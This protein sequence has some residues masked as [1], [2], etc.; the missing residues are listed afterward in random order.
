[1]INPNVSLK[2]EDVHLV[3]QL[4]ELMP[5]AFVVIDTDQRIV[6]VNQ[7]AEA[8]FQETVINLLGQ[9]L[10]VILPREVVGKHC[11]YVQRF[12]EGSEQVKMLDQ[13]GVLFGRRNNGERF[14]FLG[15]IAK[16]HL[17]EGVRL[18]IVMREV[19]EYLQTEQRRK[20][21]ERASY[22]L[23]QSLS[24]V[25]QAQDETELLQ[26]ICR[27]TVETGGY[28]FAWIGFAR[29]DAEKSVQPVAFAGQDDGYLQSIFV[30]WN[31][32]DPSGWGPVGRAIRSGNLQLSRNTA[33]DR[34]F[35][36][37]RKQALKRGFRS[38]AAFPLKIDSSQAQAALALYSSEDTFDREE[39]NLMSTLAENLA[40]GLTALRTREERD[41]KEAFLHQRVN[42][43]NLLYAITRLKGRE[44][45]SVG[46]IL[47]HIAEAI[48]QAW[49]F[50][51]IAQACI[52][53]KG[54][55]EFQTPGYAQSSL[56][57]SQP[58]VF[59]G[60]TLGSV[61]VVYTQPPPQSSQEIFLP[62]EQKTLEH[63]T[64]HVADLIR[65][66]Q[67]TNEQRKLSSALEQTADTV[68]ITDMNGV[69]EY[70]NP[71]FEANTG[72]SR[73]EAVGKKPNIMK[74]GKHPPEFYQTMWQVILQGKVYRDTVIN[75]AKDGSIFYEYKTI[76]PLYDHTGIIS[77]FLATG[78]D[79][80][81]QLRTESRLQYLA[82]HDPVTDLVNHTEFVRRVDQLI[83]EASQQSAQRV[84]AVI[85]IGMDNFKAVNELLG[86]HV[87]DK[88]LKQ[89]G[90][91]LS[92]KRI[93][94]LGRLEGDTFGLVVQ[95][96]TPRLTGGI[97]QSF[98][99]QIAQPLSV[100]S[101]GQDVVL[102]ATA[103]ISCYPGD[104]GSGVELVQLA[105]T[106]MSRAKRSGIQRFEFFTPDM[107][108]MS[109]ERLRLNKELLDALQENQF[110]LYFQ[111]Q[112]N[113]ATGRISGAEAL[114]RWNHPTRGILGPQEF[115]PVLE[116]MGRIGEMG[117]FVLHQACRTMAHIKDIGLK[118]PKI[119]VNLAAPQLEDPALGSKIADTLQAAGLS[120]GQLEL[121]VTESLLISS[122]E[123]V[124]NQLSEL[125][126]MGI[127]VALDDFGT[128]YSSL[129]YL[130]RYP[131]SKLKIDKSFVWNMAKGDKDY[132]V[133]KAIISLGH[134]LQI[135]VLAEGVENDEHVRIL[136]GLGCK[137][138]QGYLYSPPVDEKAFI[139]YLKSN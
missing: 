18:A 117:I 36:L 138:V 33:K 77:H 78:K 67:M 76:T 5:D 99:D 105:E 112:I 49:K 137:L 31:K 17:P 109:L 87:G 130:T 110:I 80:T 54:Y 57:M 96:A 119:A 38:V 115:I 34:D 126:N 62:Q 58:I 95:G 121:E 29:D 85:A 19:T 70:V 135:K 40:F 73:E 46:D 108:D 139:A 10:D 91:R 65:H 100:E 134:S 7:Q 107:Q 114:V 23:S 93:L 55:G 122:Y 37:W 61:E 11:R 104:A 125:L 52:R 16:L 24:A 14:S 90:K 6:Q 120:P 66:V 75:R 45:L 89:V 98:L 22:C 28:L 26:D 39:V 12:L 47:A 113:I 124:Q 32:N 42:E 15:T 3:R 60:Q 30:S 20:H 102:T 81:A 83:A 129:Q 35:G 136:R 68:V 127:G 21:V 128:G 13:R 8:L 79:L 94:T 103:G 63:V 50:P 92:D 64:F 69:I 106:A 43:L 84:F 44:D 131:F 88:V 133:V 71:S 48:R 132:E 25:I 97:V 118:V 116:D 111:P 4:L 101:S 123:Q 9:P 41:E 86:R 53:I 51:D 72:Y 2:N 59:N 27:I 56:S 74:S 82:S 1:M